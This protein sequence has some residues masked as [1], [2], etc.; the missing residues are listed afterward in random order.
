MPISPRGSDPVA[1]SSRIRDVGA[2]RYRRRYLGSGRGAGGRR[3]QPRARRCCVPARSICRPTRCYSES[4]DG[5]PLLDPRACGGRPGR[6]AATSPTPDNH[7]IV[8]LGADWW[9]RSAHSARTATWPR[10]GCVDPDGAGP[11][12]L[13]DGQF[14][15]PWGIAVDGQRRRSMWPTPGTA[16]FRSSTPR[17][18]VCASGA[19]STRPTANSAIRM[20]SSARA[21]I[22][23]DW[24][25]QPARGR[26]R[27]QTHPAASRRRAS[28]VRADR[29]RRRDRRPL[30]G[31]DRRGR[32]SA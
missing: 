22:A 15:E 6:A 26:H 29:R 30:R 31:A 1:Q 2:P 14:Y 10:R 7:R 12:E 4:Y 20:R 16:A 23:I 3:G 11:L 17:A 19:S 5:V 9:L 25:G 18:H 32:R 28:L 24:Q 8:V 27:Q 21:G 13:G